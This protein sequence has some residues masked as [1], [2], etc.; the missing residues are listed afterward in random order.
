MT[1]RHAFIAALALATALQGCH[2]VEPHEAEVEHAEG[3]AMVNRQA[4]TNPA[5]PRFHHY[6]TAVDMGDPLPSSV[7]TRG[8]SASRTWVGRGLRTH[9]VETP[10]SPL[11]LLLFTQIAFLIIGGFMLLAL[12]IG[13]LPKGQALHAS[14]VQALDP[15]RE[16]RFVKRL[17][18]LT[19][20]VLLIAALSG[21][22]AGSV[23]SID[24]ATMMP[25][26]VVVDGRT[27][28]IPAQSFVDLRLW[29]S[30]IDIDVRAGGQLLESAT[31]HLDDDVGEGVR[32]ALL[33]N[34][35]FVYSVCGL[36]LIHI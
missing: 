31:M 6:R 25:V 23:V 9:R 13:L 27:V 28:N 22:F 35:R 14:Q 20:P 30:N 7:S 16:A 33:T 4:A 26:D 2:V 24:N 19:G 29:G 11:S 5:A 36:S 17:A 18:L 10:F 12:V 1:R 8:G 3:C 32:R 21:Y 15:A 34:G